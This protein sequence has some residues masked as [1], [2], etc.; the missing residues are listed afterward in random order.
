MSQKCSRFGAFIFASLFLVGALPSS[1]RAQTTSGIDTPNG[2]LTIP[3]AIEDQQVMLMNGTGLGIGVTPTDKLDVLSSTTQISQFNT[4]SAGNS[5]VQI[6]N[7]SA[8][9]NLGVGA[10]LPYPYIYSY[11]TNFFIGADVTTP[12]FFVN[13]MSSGKVGIDTSS[14]S[15][16]LEVNGTSQF[17]NTV[18]ISNGTGF[19]GLNVWGP[20]SA[21]N[22][23]V[24]SNLT[25]LPFSSTGGNIIVQQGSVTAAAFYHNS[26]QSL[27]TSIRP[28][29]NALDKILAL[30]GVAFNWKKDGRADV[31][32]VAQNVAAVFPEVVKTNDDGMMSV[33]YDSLVGPMI[34]AIRELKSEND[35]LR[36]A[37]A[38]I[39]ELKA[40]LHDV[41]DTVQKLQK[42]QSIERTAQHDAP[43]AVW[44]AANP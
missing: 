38:Q 28:I 14:P 30:K 2:T 17:D 19:V 27:K 13:G 3:F 23:T 18:T 36:K 43:I 32:V 44:N 20:I 12:T 31:G 16:N 11:N 41:D 24:F 37:V 25:V 34:E 10:T 29:P 8:T 42:A 22:E 26:D 39:D 7:A 21:V 35:D 15:A 40:Q 1:A 4:T 9:M 5:W 33:E 6:K